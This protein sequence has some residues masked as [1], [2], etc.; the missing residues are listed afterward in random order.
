MCETCSKLTIKTPE[1]RVNDV[2]PV[3]LLLIL[4]RLHFE[5]T[6]VSIIEF[7]PVNPT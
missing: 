6:G 1:P 5:Q 2:V 7:G 4:N 3:S